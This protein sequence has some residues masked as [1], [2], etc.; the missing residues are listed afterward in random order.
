MKNDK[1]LFT[2]LERQY[3]VIAMGAPSN[4][5]WL[6]MIRKN[7]NN[8]SVIEIMNGYTQMAID[9]PHACNQ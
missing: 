6:I 9:M 5:V 8:V 2:W 7:L 4:I 3:Y 1:K